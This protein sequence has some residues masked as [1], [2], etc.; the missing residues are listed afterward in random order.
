MTK[1]LIK[2]NGITTLRGTLVPSQY[3]KKTR[4]KLGFSVHR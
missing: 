2:D 3:E 4:D 1:I